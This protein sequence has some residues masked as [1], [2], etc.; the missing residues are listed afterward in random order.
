ME[1][2]IPAVKCSLN[3][4]ILRGKTSAI[5]L[6]ELWS[7]LLAYHLIRLKM[8]QSSTAQ[9]RDP[10]SLSFTT[11]QRLLATN[12]RLCT[13][14]GRIKIIRLNKCAAA[15]ESDIG[16]AERNL[17]EIKRRPKVLALMTKLRREYQKEPKAAA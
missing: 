6:T 7:C 10:R 5:G 2:D 3:M 13:V 8:L 15:N 14:I 16:P 17:A 1:L 12:W 9:G 4:D 11:T